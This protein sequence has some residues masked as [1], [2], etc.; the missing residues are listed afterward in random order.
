MRFSLVRDGITPD[1]RQAQRE[2]SEVATDAYKIFRSHTPIK[3]GNARRK[4]VL[5]NKTTILANYDYAVPLDKGA[6]NQAPDGMTK[7]TEAFMKKRFDKI[8]KGR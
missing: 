2:I 8:L 5:E 1:I 4:T 3:T 7:P 6:S